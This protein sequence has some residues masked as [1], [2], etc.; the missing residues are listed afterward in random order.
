M[1]TDYSRLYLLIPDNTRQP[2]VLYAV[3]GL[4]GSMTNSHLIPRL[5]NTSILP[6]FCLK[7][8][9]WS[10]LYHS[11]MFYL[12]FYTNFR[13]IESINMKTFMHQLYTKSYYVRTPPPKLHVKHETWHL[14]PDM[15]HVTRDTWYVTDGG[16]WTF[17]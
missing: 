8:I 4:R 10:K 7:N 13:D 5:C 9:S 16:R 17:S 2:L 14:T 12:H 6:T 3:R 15:S 11:Y 1:I